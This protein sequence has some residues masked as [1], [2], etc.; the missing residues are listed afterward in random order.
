M[1]GRY[2]TILNMCSCLAQNVDIG[3]RSLVPEKCRAVFF[4]K[5]MG[6]SI[7]E[8]NVKR[9]SGQVSR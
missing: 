9:P 2:A 5:P 8:Q 4:P 6:G 3:R 7:T 1:P